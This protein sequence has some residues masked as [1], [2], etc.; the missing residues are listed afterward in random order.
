[1]QVSPLRKVH[2]G[3]FAVGLGVGKVVGNLPPHS[4]TTQAVHSVPVR[5]EWQQAEQTLQFARML[6]QTHPL[7]LSGEQ[8]PLPSTRAWSRRAV[9]R[10][11]RST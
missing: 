1:M 5:E 3:G 9:A 6:E 7:G 8:S 2:F 4:S 11:A 10:V